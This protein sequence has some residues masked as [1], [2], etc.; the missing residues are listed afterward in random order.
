MGTGGG[1][2]G[3]GGGTDASMGG[4]ASGTGGGTQTKPGCAAV[5]GFSAI[6]LLAA[7]RALGRKRRS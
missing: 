6:A 1:T 2:A 5:P 3:T 7:L 4:G